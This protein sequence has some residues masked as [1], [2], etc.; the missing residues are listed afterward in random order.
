MSATPCS[1]SFGSTLLKLSA[2][3]LLVLTPLSVIKLFGLP[4]TDTGFWPRLLGAVLVGL[5][6]ALFVEGRTPGSHGLGLA[7][8]VIVNVSAVSIMTTLLVLDAG[9][10]S[11][12][13]RAGDVDARVAPHPAE[14]PGDRQSLRPLAHH[15][16]GLRSA[17]G[18]RRIVH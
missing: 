4:R 13:G 2:G 11:A 17:L 10:P 1:S 6:G 16:D 8:C 7:G 12:R 5:A 18:R 15:S 14:H 9:P 3:L